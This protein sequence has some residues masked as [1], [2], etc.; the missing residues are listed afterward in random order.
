M[1]KMTKELKFIEIHYTETRTA[2]KEIPAKAK[3]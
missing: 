3:A 2:I 1:A